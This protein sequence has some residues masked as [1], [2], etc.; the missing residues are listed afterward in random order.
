MNLLCSAFVQ[1]DSI[2]FFFCIFF[3]ALEHKRN[4]YKEKDMTCA[5]KF[6][7]PLVDRTVVAGYSMAISCAVKGFPKVYIYDRTVW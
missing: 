1:D 3:V 5:P 6:T 2:S 7:Q 4:P